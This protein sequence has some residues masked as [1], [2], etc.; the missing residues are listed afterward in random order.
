[1]YIQTPRMYSFP[2]ATMTNYHKPHGLKQRNL[3]CHSSRGQ[4]SKITVTAGWHPSK[5]LKGEFLLASSSVWWLQLFLGSQLHHCNLCVCLHAAFYSPMCLCQISLCLS[6]IKTSVIG[7]RTYRMVQ[8]YLIS[9]SYLV[10]A[11][12]NIS[13]NKVGFIDSGA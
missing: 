2:R 13:L 10:I 11:T 8:N 1:M 4:K 7:F 5:G 6:L 3:F 9:R 12:N